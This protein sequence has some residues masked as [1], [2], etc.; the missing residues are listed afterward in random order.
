MRLSSLVQVLFAFLLISGLAHAQGV[1]ASGDISGTVT[2]P[3]NAVVANA[4]ITVAD[5]GKGIKRS[6]VTD[7]GGVFHFLN[8]Q[9]G[10]YSVTV[11]KTGFQTEL[12]RAWS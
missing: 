6:N 3:S 11:A 9:P 4:T 1:G 2:D 10:A 12:A 8:L 5:E 7:S